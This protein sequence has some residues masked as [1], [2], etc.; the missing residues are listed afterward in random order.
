MSEVKSKILFNR[1][2]RVNGISDLLVHLADK[3]YN[4]V[5]TSDDRYSKS[6]I[7][8]NKLLRVYHNDVSLY[9]I[10]QRYTLQPL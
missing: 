1:E 2:S 5:T 9:N 8:D 3:T 10:R 7:V 4:V 6:T